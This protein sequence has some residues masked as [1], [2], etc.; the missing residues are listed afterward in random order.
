MLPSGLLA[1]VEVLG[2]PCYWPTKRKQ[3][4]TMTPVMKTSTKKNDPER[5]FYHA[6]KE[7]G[8]EVVKALLDHPTFATKSEENEEGRNLPGSSRGYGGSHGLR[9]ACYEGDLETVKLLTEDPRIKIRGSEITAAAR[10]GNED[11]LSFLARSPRYAVTQE[12]LT[13]ALISAVNNE[14]EALAVVDFLLGEITDFLPETSEALKKA[15]SK[16]YFNLAE[17]L[18]QD[19]RINIWAWC[20]GEG[21]QGSKRPV[22]SHFA[23]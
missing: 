19:P 3:K 21:L 7:E 16:G 18:L 12:A 14:I 9:T 20:T 10:P 13:S 1:E 5:G 22:G 6:C 23:G 15:I 17:R 11:V 8:L 2:V 4:C